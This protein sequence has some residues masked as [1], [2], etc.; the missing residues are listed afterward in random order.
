MVASHMS[1]V[2]DNKPSSSHTLQVFKDSGTKRGAGVKWTAESASDL[3]RVFAV[4]R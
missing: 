2:Q 1:N 3:S 4:L